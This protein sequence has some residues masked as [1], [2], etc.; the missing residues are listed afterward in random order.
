MSVAD[1]VER[2]GGAPEDVAVV[3]PGLTW[4]YGELAQR[5]VERAGRIAPGVTP[6][7]LVAHATPATIVEI[8]AHWRVGRVV[9]PLNA[10][11]TD[12]EV[13]RAR[14]SLEGARLPENTQVV[15]WTSGTA[16][17]PRGVALSWANLEASAHASAWRLG[18]GPSDLWIAS[19]SPAH[20]GGL[21]LVTRSLLLGGALATASSRGVPRISALLDGGD[22]LQESGRVPTHLSLVPTQLLRLLDYRAGAQPPPGLRCALVGGAHAPATLV[23]RALD[24]G[25]PLALTYGATEMSSQIA[26][27]TPAETRARPGT[28]GKPLP[29]VEVGVAEDGTLRARGPTRALGYVGA[30]ADGMVADAVSAHAAGEDGGGLCDEQGWYHTGDFGRYDSDGYLRIVGRRIDR[31]VSGGVTLDAV[32]VEEVLRSHPAVVDVCVVGLPDEEW[33]ER[34]A[35]WVEPASTGCS[36]E[37]LER[38]ARPRLSAAKRP[39]VWRLEGEIPRN[40]N[41][42][43]MRS[44]V[45]RILERSGGSRGSPP[46]GR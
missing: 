45:R 29:G 23:S 41:G 36:V 19:L 2:W 38:F 27:A 25:W 28:V 39:R 1:P 43:A 40:P 9:V 6:V 21:A 33:G 5:V 46:R 16:G 20:V 30:G 14:R 35:A 26:T 18:L 3:G 34:V 8:L 17:R 42:K 44:E 24:D 13:A 4:S 12:D 15:L 11:L 32:E 37:A 22:V 7:P 31:I 10:R